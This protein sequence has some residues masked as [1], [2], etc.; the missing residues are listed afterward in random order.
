MP[1]VILG[2]HISSHLPVRR[3][4]PL[5]MLLAATACDGYISVD[6]RVY[7]RSADDTLQ[8]SE[9]FIDRD[10]PDTTGLVPLPGAAVWVFHSPKDTAATSPHTPW[11]DRDSTSVS[12]SFHTGSTTAPARFTALLRVRRTGFHGVDALFAHDT[13]RHRAVVVLTPERRPH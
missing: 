7:A 3:S 2:T 11:V 10:P 6:G 8:P 4:I 5:L 13:S 12:G 1:N 9:A